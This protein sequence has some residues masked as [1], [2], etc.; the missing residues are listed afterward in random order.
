MATESIGWIVPIDDTH[1]RI[2]VVGRVR[3]AGEIESYRTRFA[4]KLWADMTEEEHRAHPGDW[5]AMVSQ[6]PITLH[7]EEHLASSDRG[8]AMLRRLI[9][10]QIKRVEDG[11]DPVGT[12]F[13]EAGA[14]IKLTGGQY[15]IGADG[16][17]VT[18]AAEAG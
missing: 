4:G 3:E 1:F 5:E 2:Y 17:S 15:L 11:L 14:L 9:T 18:T 13:D 6:G 8:V 10:Q 16:A 12:C 7:S